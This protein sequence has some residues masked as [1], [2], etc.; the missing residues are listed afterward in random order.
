MADLTLDPR[1][2][3]R[4]A[5]NIQLLIKRRPCLCLN[6]SSHSGSFFPTKTPTLIPGAAS[7]SFPPRAPQQQG[8]ELACLYS[9]V[10]VDD[11]P[12]SRELTG[13]VADDAFLQ[14]VEPVLSRPERAV[15]R[16]CKK[17]KRCTS[18][19]QVLLYVA[20]ETLLE[21]LMLSVNPHSRAPTLP[22]SL[23]N[24]DGIVHHLFSASVISAIPS[25]DVGLLQVSESV[26]FRGDCNS[27]LDSRQQRQNRM[28]Y[29]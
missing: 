4:L 24:K 15:S 9:L 18:S 5:T 16:K 8:I 21:T 25:Y 19:S 22:P 20:L 1:F 17:K 27:P 2:D 23:A 11:E 14:L 7:P 29:V 26:I 13:A 6:D 28:P 10:A 3:R 12:E